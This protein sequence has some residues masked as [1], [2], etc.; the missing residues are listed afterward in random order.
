MLDLGTLG[1]AFSQ[2]FAL[3]DRGQVVGVSSTPTGESHAFLWQK[4]QMIEL[5]VAGEASLAYRI[6]ERGQ[7]LGSVQHADGTSGA[8]VWT[9]GV[10]ERRSIPYPAAQLPMRSH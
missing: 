1:G 8:V 3:N 5:G 4:G 7:V 6:N 9:E 10:R 2:P